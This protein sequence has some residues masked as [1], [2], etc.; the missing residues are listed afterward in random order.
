MKYI[1]L[2]HDNLSS[3]MITAGSYQAY[4]VLTNLTYVTNCTSKTA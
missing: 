2:G 3:K 4:T 1:M